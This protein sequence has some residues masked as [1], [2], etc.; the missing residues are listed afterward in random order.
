MSDK[1]IKQESYDYE[2]LAAAVLRGDLFHEKLMAAKAALR[3]VTDYAES[4]RDA[5]PNGEGRHIAA[6]CIVKRLEPYWRGENAVSTPQPAPEIM[7]DARGFYWRVFE[8][9]WSMCPTTD[10]N[11]SV[12]EPY[13]VYRPVKDVEP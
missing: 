2:E 8:D 7:M 13:V 4:I 10:D 1:G 9:F 11:L 6:D 3:D 12:P 5:W